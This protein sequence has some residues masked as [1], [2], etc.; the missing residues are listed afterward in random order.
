MTRAS[1]HAP[2]T[3]NWRTFSP[4]PVDRRGQPGR[5][6]IPFN[7]SLRVQYPWTSTAVYGHGRRT[8]LMHRY[9]TLQEYVLA[10]YSAPTDTV[11]ISYSSSTV[12]VPQVVS[13]AASAWSTPSC[14][15]QSASVLNGCADLPEG[16]THKKPRRHPGRRGLARLLPGARLMYSSDH[17]QSDPQGRR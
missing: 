14:I 4:G 1:S 7:R 6:M 3:T 9:D 16:D 2:R 5:I 11:S 12:C 15:L 8:D 10:P 13:S 17:G